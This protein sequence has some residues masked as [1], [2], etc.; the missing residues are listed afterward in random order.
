MRG[1]GVRYFAFERRKMYMKKGSLHELA[2]HW[3]QLERKTVKQRQ[4]A[5]AYYENILMEPIIQTFVENNQ[6]KAPAVVECMI[7]SVGTSYEPLI[8]N[9]KLLEPQRVLFFVHKNVRA[10]SGQGCI[11]L[12]PECG[13]I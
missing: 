3:K 10:V 5:D 13:E 6:T 8:L 11:V 12:R 1:F 9:I 7:M 2:E 4:A